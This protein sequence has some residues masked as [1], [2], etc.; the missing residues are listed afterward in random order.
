MFKELV[1][2]A[3]SGGLDSSATLCILQKSGFIN[4]LP[5]HYTYGHRGQDSEILAIKKVCK[6]LNLPLK[7]FDL[8]NIYNE[9][10]VTKISML[11]NKNAT[12]V[13]GTNF[14]LKSVSAWHPGRNLLFMTIMMTLAEAEIMKYNYD[15]V[16]FSGG[17]MQLTESSTYPDN[18]PYFTDA[19]LKAGQYGTLVG[20]RFK[21]L[22]CLSNLMKAEQF[23]LI[24]HFGLESIYSH[25]ISCDRPKV[26]DGVPHNCMKDGIPAC[27]S[28]LLSYWGSK[29]VGMN[30]M[31]LRNFYEVDDPSYE[32]FIPEHLKQN[33]T[34]SPDI[35]DIINRILLP[36]DKL[37]NLRKLIK[38]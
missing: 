21:I 18:T 9:M 23:T 31:E 4:I 29:M 16:Y 8:E 32:A 2:V 13:T 15:T 19:C 20:D 11:A 24:K 27:G 35:N 36:E 5:V 34:K 12:I 1:L 17:W 37:E 14:G 22:Y 26:I 6:D 30:D 10:E 25:T 38:K 33:F 28:G 7:I 3:C